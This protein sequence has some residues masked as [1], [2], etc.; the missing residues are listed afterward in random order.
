[1]AEKENQRV[2]L[3][4]RLLK[5]GLL[6]LLQTKEL[7]KISVSELC[8]E[9][10]INRATFYKHF[11][12]PQDVLEAVG[13]DLVMEMQRMETQSR[14]VEAAK[15]YMTDICVYLHEHRELLKVLLRCNKDTDLVRLISE[16]NRKFWARYHPAERNLG[17]DETDIQ[18]MV[19]Y[20]SSGGYYL[21]R[22]WILEDMDKTP[23]EIAE[24][25]FRFLQR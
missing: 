17:M 6:R 12:T 20:F 15:K 9:S 10:G 25:I 2:A 3:T 19:T 4:K 21:I 1:M 5:E 18:L 14:T 8:R 7:D 22:R 11:A 24:L 16:M 23:Q 13:Q